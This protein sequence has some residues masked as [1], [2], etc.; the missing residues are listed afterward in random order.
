MVPTCVSTTNINSRRLNF[1]HPVRLRKHFRSR[2]SRPKSASGTARTG[3]GNAYCSRLVEAGVRLVH[4]QWPRE[5]GDNAVDNPLWDTHAQNADRVEDVLC[6]TFDVGFSALIE[7]LDAR[8]LLDETLVVAV[9]EFGRT[10]KINGNGG[11]DHWGPVFSC[12][13]AGAG[14]SGGQVYGASDKQGAYATDN[15]CEPG[16][17]TATIF[18]LLGL[19][20][21]STFSDREGREHKVTEGEP[22]VDLLGIEP[23]TTNRMTSTGDIARVPPFDPAITLMETDFSSTAPLKPIEASSR[24]KGWRAGPLVQGDD[25]LAFGVKKVAQQVSMGLL[26]GAGRI[27][28]GA[29]AIVAQEVRSPFAGTYTLRVRLRGEGDSPAD[30]SEQFQKNFQ[31]KLQFFQFTHPDKKAAQRKELASVDVQPTFTAEPDAPYQTIELA[32]EFLNPNPGGNFSFGLGMGIAIVIEKT[33]D[34]ALEFAKNGPAAG[35]RIADVTLEFQGKS[36]ND[37]VKV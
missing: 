29:Q 3:G 1:S 19:S 25:S 7:D 27:E 28:K 8:G 14:I 34:G 10:P 13:L 22:L 26:G 30:F 11:R 16:R 24:P 9:G 18:H 35:I 15:R 17:L 12:A 32:K 36:R 23:A 37:K 20:H 21:L 33:T 5:P 6:P 2:K 4:V 31:C